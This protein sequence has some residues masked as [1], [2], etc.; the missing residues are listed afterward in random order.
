[1]TDDTSDEARVSL[2]ISTP[3]NSGAMQKAKETTQLDERRIATDVGRGI[4]PPYNPETLASFQE[5]N[6]THQACL[7]KKARYE[8]GYGFDIVPH[9]SADSPDPDGDAYQAVNNFWH[10]SDSKWSIGPENTTAATPE[11]VL[12][13]SRLDYHGIGWA[14]LEILVEGDGTPVGLAH[15]PSATTRVRKTTTEIET[16][17]GETREEIESGHGYVQIRQGRRRYFGEAG[18]RYGDDPTFVD[19]ETGEVASSAEDL[20]NGPANELLFIPNPSPLSLYYGIPD[21]VASMRT[22][23]ADEAAQEMNH[24]MFDNL[25]IPH[26]AIKVYG[27][28][29][30]EESKQELRELQQNLKGQRYRTAILEVDGF[31]FQ[32]DDPL[33]EGDPSDV[34]IEFEP[35]GAT[36]QGDMEFQEFRRRNEH[37]IAKVHE[38]P[39]ILINVTD[40]SNRSNSQAQ[41]QE[42]AEDVIAPEQA[43]FE[44]RLY[45]ILHQT[46]LGVD[47]WTIDFVLRGA[48]QPAEE[49]RTA[50]SK[51][52]AVRGAIPVDRA[53][54]MIGQDP[55]P[56]DH[57]VDGQTLVANVGSEFD[58]D[59][60]GTQAS[61]PED[62]PPKENKVGT[63]SGV[64]V[65]ADDP[66]SPDETRVDMMQFDSSNLVAGLYDRQTRDLYI[67]F[68]GDPVDRIYVYLD[69]PEETW[70]GLKEASSHG[71][72]HHENVKWD[73][74]YEEL[75]DTSGWPQ[76]GA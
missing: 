45:R 35:L 31:E 49:A 13:L 58:E 64:T 20:P 67:R 2:S 25:G 65:E 37:E 48:D 19:K 68:H 5:L 22:M 42:F 8:C 24:D 76:I 12:E 15:V 40:T 27:G 53:L 34:E 17:N 57:P 60:S 54:D 51:I 23:A 73:Y 63:R 44:A 11:E 62:A 41:V 7:R 70:Q 55:L 36:D 46:A 47:D 71:S 29:L 28:T 4:V 72:F 52:Q 66:L 6:E 26:Y 16:A 30:T 38:V 75:T 14:S 43:K 32:S 69:V 50:R 59:A 21:W 1:M 9:P 18:D 61:R 3:G 33:A 74:V 10:G 39:P 56:D